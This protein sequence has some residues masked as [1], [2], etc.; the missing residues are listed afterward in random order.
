MF[1]ICLL[2][3]LGH[4]IQQLQYQQAQDRELLKSIPDPVN[5]FISKWNWSWNTRLYSSTYVLKAW[6]GFLTVTLGTSMATS[7]HHHDQGSVPAILAVAVWRDLHRLVLPFWPPMNVVA[8]LHWA[9]L[10]WVVSFHLG[11]GGSR[12]EGSAWLLGLLLALS[13]AMALRGWHVAQLMLRPCSHLYSYPC[14]LR[15]TGVHGTV[16]AEAA[17]DLA[18]DFDLFWVMFLLTDQGS[19]DWLPLEISCCYLHACLAV[20]IKPCPLAWLYAWPSAF[21]KG[22][23][24]YLHLIWSSVF[25]CPVPLPPTTCQPEGAWST[26]P[27]TF[28][29]TLGVDE[30]AHIWLPLLLSAWASF[31]PSIMLLLQSWWP[32]IGV[33]QCIW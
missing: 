31:A 20:S 8:V 11:P 7:K 32:P 15:S 5:Y 33:S 14:V 29:V 28:S 30:H 25:Q 19:T 10:P 23:V 3:W 4:Q 13:V 16:R 27:P 22:W 1:F 24:V 2:L 17:S 6:L 21:G 18:S 26:S 12:L 9:Q